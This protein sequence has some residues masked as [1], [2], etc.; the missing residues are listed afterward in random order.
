MCQKAFITRM[1]THSFSSLI[2]QINEA[3]AEAI[4]SMGFTFFL[5]VDLKHIPGK[6]SEWMVESFDPN[7][8]CFTLLD[9]H[10]FSNT[11]F[12]VYATMGVPL[13]GEWK[14]SKSPSLRRMK[15]MMRY[16]PRGLRDG[17]SK[18]MPRKSLERWSSFRPK[19]TGGPKNCNCRKCILKYIKDVSQ[20]AS[21]DW[22]QFVLDKLIDSV[23]HC[24]ESTAAKVKANNDV[25]APS[26]SPT[27]PFHKLD[28]EAEI[29]GDTLVSDANII[30]EKEG[31]HEDV[32]L[33]QPKSVMKKG[34]SI[35]SYSLGLGLSQPDSQSLVPQTTSAPHPGTV[36]V[37]ED[38]GGE[39]DDDNAPLRFPLRNS[40]QVNRKLNI[41]KLAEKK[42][43]EGNEPSCKKVEAR[44]HNI[45]IRKAT[46]KPQ[47]VEQKKRILRPFGEQEATDSRKPKL[48]KELTK[49]GS[50]L[51]QDELTISNEPLFD[52][53]GDKEAI[54]VSMD[55][56]KPRE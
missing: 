3:S 15:S 4:R 39:D 40:S 28:G 51:S 24:K 6:F 31:H 37:N 41:K 26:F 7:A 25:C 34:D 10:N 14:S 1:S 29:L 20:I 32:V 42:P 47:P 8:M 22:C 9:G 43:K 52:N 35:P 23:R 27:L 33:D 36:G 17:N 38:D 48:T 50:K 12:D 54:R 46:L 21:L 13:G 55:T 53:Y 18:R 45:K 16:L 30:V 5:K 49:L 2:A 44:R 56:L 19:R 11:A